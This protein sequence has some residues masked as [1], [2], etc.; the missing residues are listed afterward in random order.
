MA[1]F[2]GQSIQAKRLLDAFAGD[3]KIEM[4]FIPN[5]PANFGQNVKFLRTLTTSLK[6]WFS[7]FCKI[8]KSK[9]RSY[10]FIGNDELYYFNSAAAL[11]RKI[12]RKKNDSALSH[13]RSRNASQTLEK[14]AANDANVR[15]NR[16]SVEI[17]S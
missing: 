9:S 14:V 5:N 3:E 16:R 8:A 11:C 1:Q 2:G 15:P 4:I 6:F 10:F 17:F 13:G 7:L 12:I